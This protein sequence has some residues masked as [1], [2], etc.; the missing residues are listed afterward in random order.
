[1]FVLLIQCENTKQESQLILQGGDDDSRLSEIPVEAES[2]FEEHIRTLVAIAKSG[3]ASVVLSSFAT[4][5][6]PS[7]D[8][9]SPSDTIQ[10]LSEFQRE[11]I[12]GIYSFTPG[13][14]IS[15]FFD[16]ITR[17]NKILHDVAAQENVGWV[18]NGDMIPH[19]DQYFVDRVHFSALGA[20]LM[21]ENFALHLR[22]VLRESSD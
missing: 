11:N 13:L 9:D 3:G 17:Y 6:D 8:W 1:M 4:L 16:G 20:K 14:N 7:L 12:G 22:R 15:A 5:H 21:G 18:D 19:E 2:A 10:K